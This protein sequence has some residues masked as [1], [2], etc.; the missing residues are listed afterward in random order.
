MAAYVMLIKITDISSSLEFLKSLFP[1]QV[2]EGLP[3]VVLKHQL[4][5]LHED[6]TT[7]DRHI[8]SGQLPL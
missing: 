6:R 4:Y 3:V 2:F 8:V 7:V 1:T 5:S